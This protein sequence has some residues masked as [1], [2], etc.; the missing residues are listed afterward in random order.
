[1]GAVK[2]RHPIAPGAARLRAAR[3]LRDQRG[4]SSTEYVILLI[5]VALVGI[6]GWRMFGDS[7]RDRAATASSEVGGLDQTASPS[8]RGGGIRVARTSSSAL[9]DATADATPPPTDEERWA[10]PAFI[11]GFAAVLV[12]GVIA[13][14]MRNRGG[15]GDAGDGAAPAG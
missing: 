6:A 5:V 12:L 3:G 4:L 13:R 7:A 14:R 1:M 10:T 2:G 9:D 8:A 11:L 15:G